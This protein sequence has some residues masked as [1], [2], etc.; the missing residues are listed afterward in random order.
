MLDTSIIIEA[1]KGS[2]SYEQG[3]ISVLTLLEFLR[4]IPSEKRAAAK[5]LLED[6]Y[7]VVGMTNSVVLKYCELYESLKKDGRLLPDADLIIAATA[8]AVGEPIVTRD[9]GFRR[10]EKSGLKLTIR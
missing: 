3:K 4:G 2:T 8:L 10:L 7:D 5:S 1:L 6:A 9:R